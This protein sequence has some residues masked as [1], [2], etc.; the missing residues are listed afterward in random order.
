[1]T[2]KC[3]TFSRLDGAPVAWAVADREIGY[4]EAEA[5]MKTRATA[6]AS[7][8][9]DEAVWLLEHPPLYSAGTSAQS[10][11]LLDANRFPVFE[12]GRGGQFTYHGPGQ[13]VVYLMLDLRARNRDVRC[14]VRNL[15][16]WVIGA[17][18]HFNI[19]GYTVPGR[20]GVWVKRPD[21]G[22]LA[23][24]KIA[25]I[26]VRVS[27]WVSY[28]GISLNVHPDLSHYAGIVPCGIA[29]QGVT[30]FEDL[31]QLVSMPEVDIALRETFEDYFGAT[32]SVSFPRFA[33]TVATTP[34]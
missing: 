21:K 16:N 23:E 14:F 1:M 4:R 5:A 15:E 6:I 11:D 26:G 2:D 8:N 19:A 28:H 7:G 27:K 33:G 25:A 34:A 10:G 32:K 22:I 17:L 31:G 18:A 24:D 12:S 3:T 13:R 30:S 20:V 29:D 9:A